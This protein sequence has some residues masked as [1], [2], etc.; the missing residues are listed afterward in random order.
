MIKSS[1]NGGNTLRREDML[2]M[3]NIRKYV[4]SD[5]L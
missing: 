1:L 4:E 2:R 3:S 5:V